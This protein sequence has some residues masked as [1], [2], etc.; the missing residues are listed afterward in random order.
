MRTFINPN[1]LGVIVENKALNDQTNQISIRIDSLENIPAK[2]DAYIIA[3]RG[4][5]KPRNKYHSVELIGIPD[6]NNL[7]TF[8]ID[9]SN[10][11]KE[12]LNL[13]NG[14]KV[15]IKGPFNQS[16]KQVS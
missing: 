8:K 7:L 10:D 4:I 11:K 2:N 15:R 12:L 1:S 6:E 13:K 9:R 14:S 5:R 16:L 3:L